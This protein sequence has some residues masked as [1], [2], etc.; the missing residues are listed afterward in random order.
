M[1]NNR[2]E[3]MGRLIKPLPVTGGL[4]DNDDN[5]VEKDLKVLFRMGT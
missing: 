5:L 2:E 3:L 1:K 4:L